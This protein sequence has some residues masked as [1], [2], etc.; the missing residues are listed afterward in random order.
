MD[1]PTRILNEYCRGGIARFRDLDGGW[2]RNGRSWSCSYC[3][4]MSVDELRECLGAV[5][6]LR[7]DLNDRRD[8][9]Y[10]DRYPHAGD[11]PTSEGSHCVC[12]VKRGG[13][14][15]KFYLRHL[16]DDGIEEDERQSL[17]MRLMAECTRS[18][19]ELM[20]RWRAED[21]EQAEP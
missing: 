11:C 9:V 3:G 18:R 5:P 21:E 4:S 15:I 12:D 10:I 13:G 1:S 6:P 8:K 16:Y 17:Y 14:P 20:A 7:Y 2:R 19:S